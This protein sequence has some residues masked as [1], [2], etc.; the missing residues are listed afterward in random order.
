MK[1]TSCVGKELS[2][3]PSARAGILPKGEAVTS[4]SC[5]D[6]AYGGGLDSLGLEAFEDAGLVPGATVCVVTDK[7]LLVAAE[8][9]EVDHYPVRV[10]FKVR[11]LT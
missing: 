11:T 3:L 2:T 9:K 10:A 1:W 7:N 8:V 6:A 5:R 4:D